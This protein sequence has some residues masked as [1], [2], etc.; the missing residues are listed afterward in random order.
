MVA[1][2]NAAGVPNIVASVING[3][4]IKLRNNIG[5]AINIV[6]ITADTNGNNFAGTNSISSIPA[7]TPA[8][9]TT[10]AL[11]LKRTDGGPMTIRDYQGSFLTDAGVLSGQ[12]GRY[13]LGLY[14]EQGLRSSKTTVVADITARDALYPLVGDQAYVIDAGNGEW[15][16]FVFDGS[17]WKRVGNERSDATDARTLVLDVDLSTTTGVQSIGYIT[18][19]RTVIGV[20]ILVTAPGPSNA[21]VTVG[22]AA[23][24][25]EFVT[26][27]DS[28]LSQTGQYSIDSSYRTTSY[29]EVVAEITRPT[30]GAGQFTVILTYV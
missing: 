20:K 25:N 8:N 28:I 26:A 9:T 16:V 29:T 5:A 17:Q 14:I 2:I 21:T 6:N 30:P 27:E 4:D 22:T 18:S 1:D 10:Y 15:A 13:A 11:R 23:N 7:T 3:S 24:T 19:D 12:N